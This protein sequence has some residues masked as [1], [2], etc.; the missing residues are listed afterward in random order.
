MQ[1]LFWLPNSCILEQGVRG[2]LLKLKRQKLK[3][4]KKIFLFYTADGNLLL[5]ESVQAKKEIYEYFKK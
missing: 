3:W 4:N 1:D 2:S 5:Q